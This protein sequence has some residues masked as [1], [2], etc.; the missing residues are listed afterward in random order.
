MKIYHK[1]DKKA[2][3]FRTNYSLVVNQAW[4]KKL[5]KQFP[6]LP[7]SGKDIHKII[8]TF[9]MLCRK[10]IT[11]TR[12]GLQLPEQL[13]H[14]FIGAFKPKNEDPMR[15]IA[16]YGKR[17]PVPIWSCKV[18]Y[19][20]YGSKYPFKNNRLWGFDPNRILTGEVS[21]AFEKNHKLYIIIDNYARINNIYR[22]AN[23][24]VWEIVKQNL[25]QQKN[26]EE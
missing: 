6:E 4:L 24:K 17:K 12:D 7:L 2:P 9:H 13:G 16:I 26:E 20:T 21:K 11:E 10:V 18:F 1:A 15:Q 8:D 14:I 23:E 3:R 25:A 19:T 22:K 5:K